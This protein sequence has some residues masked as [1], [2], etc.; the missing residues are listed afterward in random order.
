MVVVAPVKKQSTV[1]N[2]AAAAA[3]KA[4]L[5]GPTKVKDEVKDVKEESADGSTPK[6]ERVEDATMDDAVSIKEDDPVKADMEDTS[7]VKMEESVSP[8]TRKAD[9]VDGVGKVGDAEEEFD[10]DDDDNDDD[11][12]AEEAAP[13]IPIPMVIDGD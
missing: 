6:D 5:L 10:K 7:D 11:D 4:S 9:S 13:I 3:F 1:A 2:E 12:D 8:G